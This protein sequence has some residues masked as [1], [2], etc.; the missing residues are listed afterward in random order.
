L[1]QLIVKLRRNLVIVRESNDPHVPARANGED[2]RIDLWWSAPSPHAALRLAIAILLRRSADWRDAALHV[3]TIV[4]DASKRDEA[5]TRLKQYLA[6]ARIR[7]TPVVLERNGEELYEVISRS[8]ADA[9]LVFLGIRPPRDD[10][11]AQEYSEYYRK[12]LNA[13]ETLPP[14]AM[15]MAGETLEFDQIFETD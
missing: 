6:E 11:S 13:T 7:A 4:D 9:D 3:K 2:R 8:S 1:I 10:Q 5:E 12:L 14:T 15:V